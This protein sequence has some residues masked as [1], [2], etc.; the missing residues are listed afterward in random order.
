MGPTTTYESRRLV[1]V[2]FSA[3]N[4]LRRQP[5]SP[6]PTSRNDSLVC[7]LSPPL[8]NHQDHQRDCVSRWFSALPTPQRHLD[9]ATST[10][11]PTSHRDSLV[12]FFF[13]FRVVAV[14]FLLVFIFKLFLFYTRCSESEG[15]GR[16]WPGPDPT[17]LARGQ[18][19]P[20][21]GPS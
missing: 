16:P 4:K 9:D 14:K 17:L 13:F 19:D 7:R 12:C 6:P 2:S 1:G 8:V 3:L 21:P 15:Q 11:T 20:G 10:T 5:P 18:L